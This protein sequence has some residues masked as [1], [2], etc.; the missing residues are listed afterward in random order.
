M[1]KPPGMPLHVFL[2]LLWMP[3]ILL[4]GADAWPEERLQALRREIAR[5][6]ELY[7]RK[8]EAEIS[9]A[10][11]DRLVQSL[12]ELEDAAGNPACVPRTPRECSGD[13]VERAH[14]VFMSGL[15]KARRTEDLVRFHRDL[16]T[17]IGKTEPVY[18]IEPKV[19]GMAFS[20]VY[21]DG[22][23]DRVLTRG[24]GRAGQ[25]ITAHFHAAGLLPEQLAGGVGPM[26][27]AIVELRGEVYVPLEKFAE[28]N[29]ERVSGG[30]K[31]FVS[32]RSLTVGGFGLRDPAELASRGLEVV[33][34]GWGAWHPAPSRPASYEAFR[35]WLRDRD[36]P[37]IGE[38]RA[39]RG[40]G[41]L[42]AGLED[43]SGERSKWPYA[44]DGLV[45]KLNRVD[46]WFRL[47]SDPAGPDWALAWKFPPETA[48]TRLLGIT[49]Q[50]GETGLLTPV[51]ELEPV[52]LKG[53]TITRATLH[54]R[55]FITA[56][57]YRIGDTVRLELAGEVIPQL[58]GVVSEKRSPGSEPPA[59]PRLCPGCGQ[60][61]ELDSGKVRIH[62]RNPVHGKAEKTP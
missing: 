16:S 12:E 41:E 32:P 36:L 40:I 25:D 18:I 35:K 60:P 56:G 7:Y 62:C 26:I 50:V 33:F 29:R 52:L 57:D 4:S 58:L 28:I 24:N 34:F 42:L 45:I 2:L 9:D 46:D 3:Q 37:V 30:F 11:Y 43:L 21:L 23:L 22:V 27:P 39:A 5:H 8:G 38:S 51:A 59:V 44:C 61:L 10:A 6:D 53:R 13:S 54:N 14:I 55:D 47:G 19:D 1:N 17:R 15:H 20:A 31:P 49:W 48:T